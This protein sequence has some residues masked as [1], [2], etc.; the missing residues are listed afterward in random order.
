MKHVYLRGKKGEGRRGGGGRGEEAVGVWGAV[1]RGSEVFR[2]SW[3][4]GFLSKQM[5]FFNAAGHHDLP[6]S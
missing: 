5:L 6:K 2:S 1:G 4:R 3:K